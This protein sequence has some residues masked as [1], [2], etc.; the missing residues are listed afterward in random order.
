[1]SVGAISYQR[2]VILQ[3]FHRSLQ[4]DAAF[5]IHGQKGLAPS[6]KMRILLGSDH[7]IIPQQRIGC[8]LIVIDGK[9]LTSHIDLRR[10]LIILIRNGI[11]H[12]CGFRTGKSGRI[13]QYLLP[14]CMR[15]RLDCHQRFSGRGN[16]TDQ[17]PGTV[18]A[19]IRTEFPECF[20]IIIGLSSD[21][22]CVHL[23]LRSG[24]IKRQAHQIHI[25]T[26]PGLIQLIIMT[27]QN[28]LLPQRQ[29]IIENTRIIR[30]QRFRQRKQLIGIHRRRKL[31]DMSVAAVIHCGMYLM[32]QIA[33]KDLIIL[34]HRIEIIQKLL[35]FRD[36]LVFFQIILPGRHKG[37][38]LLS[39]RC[40]DLPEIAEIALRRRHH[41]AGPG[42]PQHDSTAGKNILHLIGFQ[43]MGPGIRI[44]IGKIIGIDKCPLRHAVFVQISEILCQSQFFQGRPVPCID[45]YLSG[46]LRPSV[47]EHDLGDQIFYRGEFPVILSVFDQRRRTRPVIVPDIILY[48]VIRLRN[49]PDIDLKIFKILQIIQFIQDILH[50][51]PDVP[52]QPEDDHALLIDFII[53]IIILYG[54]LLRLQTV[55][56]DQPV[57]FRQQFLSFPK[58]VDALQLLAFSLRNRKQRRVQNILRLNI[59]VI[60]YIFVRSF[61]ILLREYKSAL[62]SQHDIID[63]FAVVVIPVVEE[64]IRSGNI[65]RLHLT[66]VR[67]VFRQQFDQ[68]VI[69]MADLAERHRIVEEA[70]LLVM[71]RD[72]LVMQINERLSHIRKVELDAGEIR[73]HQRRLTEHPLIAHIAH[74]RNDIHIVVP[75]KVLH[76]C[77]DDGMQ[78]VLDPVAVFF[79]G[80]NEP[81][82]VDQRIEDLIIHAF[83][84]QRIVL[85]LLA[86]ARADRGRRLHAPG[87]A[88]HDLLLIIIDKPV[89]AR[90][91]GQLQRIIALIIIDRMR[92]IPDLIFGG[93]EIQSRIITQSLLRHGDLLHAHAMLHAADMKVRQIPDIAGIDHA[94]VIEGINRGIRND[95]HIGHHEDQSVLYGPAYKRL[96]AVLLQPF[97]IRRILIDQIVMFDVLF[98]C[99]SI[100]VQILRRI[101]ALIDLIQIHPDGLVLD[102]RTEEPVCQPDQNEK[103]GSLPVFLRKKHLL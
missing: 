32:M 4:R 95:H 74:S 69:V 101:P 30:D 11:K 28:D 13:D 29:I 68:L 73:H 86:F 24:L 43:K 2:V 42:I 71:L 39:V 70:A 3:I 22:R 102:P 45:D 57:R 33:V 37:I 16:E 10:F 103:P 31:S 6:G 58:I 27:I 79:R 81:F 15:N 83:P 92:K 7:R 35:R 85:S 62:I 80:G 75:V 61:C 100:T 66:A 46:F 44:R 5:F 88:D 50:I 90:N 1:M 23:F 25:G 98:L 49:G 64:I 76:L 12:L 20:R 36:H 60:L 72:I 38:E 9:H 99:R 67:H 54:C 65:F 91:T 52:A 48:D 87:G 51:S 94:E 55:F 19:V 78:D 56:F 21:D 26:A 63:P 77:T 97:I 93:A 17:L 89:I 14:A 84:E 59:L 34:Q 82:I 47:R 96:K 40:Q 53:V 8:I 18:R 41:T